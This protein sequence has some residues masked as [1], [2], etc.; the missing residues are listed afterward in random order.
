M[1][2]IGK[3]VTPLS[4]VASDK[5]LYYGCTYI[6][7]KNSPYYLIIYVYIPC[8]LP[9]SRCQHYLAQPF[10]G[11]REM[12]LSVCALEGPL[13]RHMRTHTSHASGRQHT[14]TECG[15]GFTEAC[16]LRKH[17]MTHTGERLY[18][19]FECG[20][21]F[22]RAGHLKE[23]HMRSHTGERPYTRTGC[24][25]GFNQAGSLE[26]HMRTHTGKRLYTCTECGK[27][28]T[29]AGDVRKHMRSHT[30]E[31]PHM[32][33]ECGKGVYRARFPDET[34]EDSH[35]WVG[36]QLTLRACERLG[37]IRI[38]DSIWI[39]FSYRYKDTKLHLWYLCGSCISYSSELSSLQ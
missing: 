24:G 22:T 35:W 39:W 27:G 25:K 15:K 17:Q 1:H 34:R 6:L 20:K 14:C 36:W 3:T 8:C 10:A 9:F 19:S 37:D 18:S 32:T 23:Q 30:G 31:R 4:T 38:L 28:F 21:G 29:Q 26:W 12:V 33:T 7:L 5:P 13:K 2:S 11:L 16:D